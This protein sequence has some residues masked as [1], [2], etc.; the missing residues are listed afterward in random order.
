[1][2]IRQPF[3]GSARVKFEEMAQTFG[4]NLYK[5]QFDAA[6]ASLNQ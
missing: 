1:M 5:N 3:A 2:K 6:H 4:D